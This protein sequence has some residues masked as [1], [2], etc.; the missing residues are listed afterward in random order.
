MPAGE[1]ALSNL[2]VGIKEKERLK[3]VARASN[4]LYWFATEILGYDLL[5]RDFHLPMMDEMDVSDKAHLAG[6]PVKDDLDM[7]M[8]DGYKTTVY[9]ARALRRLI[10]DPTTTFIWW[11]AVEDMAVES[12]VS[13]GEQLQ[14]NKELR[15]LLPSEYRPSVSQRKFATANGFRLP[16]T[17]PKM[18][19]T[20]RMYGSGS[21][22]TGGKCVIGV[23]DDIIGH[24]TI[25]DSGMPKIRRWL[26]NTVSNVVRTDV[27]RKWAVGTHWDIDDVWMDMRKSP[28]WNVRIRSC[29]ELQGKPDWDGEPQVYADKYFKKKRR[30]MTGYQFSCQMMNDPLPDED[31][32]WN[33]E[34]CEKTTT[35]VEAGKGNGEVFVLSDPA[36]RQVGSLS[37]IGEKARGDASKDFWALAVVR[38]RVWGVIQQI[39]LLDGVASRDW[40]TDQ[41]LA[42]ACTLMKKWNTNKFFNETYGGLGADMSDRMLHIAPQNGVRPYLDTKTGRLPRFSDSHASGAKNLRFEALAD[43]AKRGEFLICDSVPD[44]FLHGDGDK[45]GFL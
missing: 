36:P 15:L 31:R 23:L 30:E 22:A 16:H 34:L 32:A 26:G 43:R 2:V 24:N 14:Q 4:S 45:T 17:D 40:P 1:V 5:T 8:R 37:G 3:L 29:Y 28:D 21:E 38:I 33:Q 19:K 9:R 7:W 11:H 39:I 25:E 27:G 10:A 18:P 35:F 6:K 20:M 41:G 42:A 12:G 44:A 13:I